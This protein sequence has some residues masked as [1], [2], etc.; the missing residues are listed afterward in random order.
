MI[1][2]LAQ[3]AVMVEEVR[4]PLHLRDRVVRRPPQHG[5]QDPA[6][7]GEGAQGALPPREAEEVRVAGRV[8]EV[9]LAAALVQPRGLEEPASVVVGGDGLARLRGQDG[10]LLDLPV[11]LVHVVGEFRHARTLRGLLGAGALA[12]LLPGGVVR[13]CLSSLVA[14]ELAAP[15]AAEVEV[16]LAVVVDEGGR[17]DAVGT[18]NGLRVRGE[19]PLGAGALRDADAED[20]VLVAGGEVEVVLAVL[21]GGVGGP[22]LLGDPGDVLGAEDDAVVCHGAGGGV[23]GGEG[24]DVVV[25]HVVLVA[26]VV[27][28]GA[29]VTVVGWVD[30][31][32]AVEDVGRGVGCEGAGDERRHGDD[33]MM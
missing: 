28:L 19:G 27:V 6:A 2:A 17:V 15:D 4:P 23:E 20:T 29:G 14:L 12:A 16:G 22:E 3:L 8:R 31:D 11:E 18:L 30:V 33:L 21:G 9:V 1:H 10:D 26:I 7:V 24:E 13:G 32:T 25:G 5:L